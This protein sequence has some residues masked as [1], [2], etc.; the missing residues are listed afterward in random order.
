MTGMRPAELCGLRVRNVDLIRGS[1]HI[2]ESLLPVH[3]FGE[4]PYRAAVTGPPKTSAG[5]RSVPIPEW[6]CADISALLAERA[7]KRGTPVD[8]DEYVFQTRYGSPLNRDR[9]RAKVVRPALV[10][11][12]LPESIR[13]Y[14][15]RHSNASLLIESGCQSARRGATVGPHGPWYDASGLRAPLRWGPGGP[16]STTRRSPRFDHRASPA[17]AG[18]P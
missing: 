8:P 3:S 17:D 5:D 4:E 18:C 13:T 1:V 9:F 2:C 14:D 16:D 10:A 7:D 6:L 15:M 12:G 11:A